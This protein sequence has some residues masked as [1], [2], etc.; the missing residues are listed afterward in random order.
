MT[1][2]RGQAD[3]NPELESGTP[4]QRFTPPARPIDLLDE[5]ALAHRPTPTVHS[6]DAFDAD[7]EPGR[8]HSPSEGAVPVAEAG[9]VRG[10]FDSGF[11][12]RLYNPALDAFF[13][14][15]RFGDSHDQGPFGSR[16]FELPSIDGA[17]GDVT[18]SSASDAAEH[19][20]AFIALPHGEAFAL[21]LDTGAEVFGVHERDMT[22]GGGGRSP[23]DAH[24][25]SVAGRPC[26]RYRVR[27]PGARLRSLGPGIEK[28]RLGRHSGNSRPHYP[29]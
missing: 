11:V 2:W 16:S 7:E 4:A 28:G 21:P 20:D 10:L 15:S 23:V 25:A 26:P 5:E 29:V 17:S 8:Y 6:I 3:W 14:E 9:A 19:G 12:A 24:P 27:A 1:N 22:F 18:V 13:I